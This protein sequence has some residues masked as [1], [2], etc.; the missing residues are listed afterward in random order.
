MASGDEEKG[1]LD[2]LEDNRIDSGIDS[3]KS[4][5][6]DEHH[7]KPGGHAHRPGD[8]GEVR[9]KLDSVVEERHDS[10]Y[11]STSITVDS[12]TDI[13]EKTCSTADPRDTGSEET[14]DPNEGEVDLD[15]LTTITDDGDTFLHL[16][17]IH[18][19]TDCAN[20]LIEIFPKEV[21]DIQNN[22]YQTPLHLATYLDLPAV[23]QRLVEAGAS[24]FLQDRVG[25]TP[26]HV[27][28]EQGK[29]EC[30]TK[31]TQNA[32]A[33]Q[34]KPVMEAQNW[35]GV[36]C[37]HVAT[38]HKRHRLMK[39][40]IKKGANLNAQEGTSGKTPLHMAV[41]LHDV[42]SVT[43][44]LNQGAN[45]DAAMFNGCTPLHLA[46]GRQDAAIAN[47]LCQSGA[48]QMI[49][50]ME[51]ETALDLADG[52]DH[53]LALFLFDDI[54]MSGRPVVGVNF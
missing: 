25:N 36:T 29:S 51:D 19:A 43:L 31:M 9:D 52:N 37:L 8:D 33:S 1:K 30:A 7:P 14:S 47:L 42:T 24:L 4:F 35:R 27:A 5:S 48:D 40:L 16:A 45:V 10:A 21:L 50:N 12:L 20:Q 41:E 26:L 22:L 39:L 6:K 2:L 28:C 44:L 15:L 11:I 46:V 18:E 3:Y 49:R 32:T 38:M 23:V 54:Q 34:L 17:I 53:M 13:L